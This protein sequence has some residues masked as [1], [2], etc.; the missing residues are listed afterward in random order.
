MNMLVTSI[1]LGTMDMPGYLRLV[2]DS[3]TKTKGIALAFKKGNRLDLAKKALV[4]V[5]MMT[6]EVD[7]VESQ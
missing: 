6:S 2:K 1:Q 5:K 3:I 7:E 4:R